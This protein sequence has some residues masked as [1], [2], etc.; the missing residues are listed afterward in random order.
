LLYPASILLAVIIAMRSAFSTMT[1]RVTWKGRHLA[2]TS[3]IPE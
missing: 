2:T 1:G 3:H